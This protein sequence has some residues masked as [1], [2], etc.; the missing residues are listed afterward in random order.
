MPK[1]SSYYTNTVC[2]WY[3][4]ATQQLHFIDD[5]QLMTESVVDDTLLPTMLHI[6]HTLI[7]F[8]G[9]LK[10]CLVYSMSHF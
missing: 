1:V 4:Y 2:T 3:V 8:F 5:A 7:Q 6:K 9:V 10:F